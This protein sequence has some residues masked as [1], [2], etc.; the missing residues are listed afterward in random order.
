M[1]A[2]KGLSRRSFL[3]GTAVVGAGAALFGMAGCSPSGASSEASAEAGS[4]AG[5]AEN[6]TVQAGYLT[7]F[8][9]L[10]EEPAI[11]DADIVETVDA[12]VVVIGGGN[13]GVCAALGAAEAGAKV[14]VLKTQTDD[15]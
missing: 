9:W 11:D 15:L 4:A 12:E 10:G 5:V 8:D 14:V 13:A 1:N 2:S 3:T 6:A 7:Y